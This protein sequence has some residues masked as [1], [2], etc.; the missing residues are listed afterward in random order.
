[1]AETR[2]IFTHSEKGL[3]IT[4]CKS[5][6]DL[7]TKS[8]VPNTSEW[9]TTIEVMLIREQSPDHAQCRWISTAIMLADPL[10]KPMDSTFLRTTLSLG[11]FRIYDENKTLQENA[12]R[13]YGTTWVRELGEKFI[14]KESKTDVNSQDVP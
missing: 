12:N 10:T 4:D 1:M 9:R 7:M 11:R 3:L 5:L 13:K 2:T 8:A 14:N 6:F